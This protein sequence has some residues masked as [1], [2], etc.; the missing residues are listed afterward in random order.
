LSRASEDRIARLDD[1]SK[2]FVALD[3]QGIERCEQCVLIENGLFVFMLRSRI[4]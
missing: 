3:H 2:L 1:S 4:G